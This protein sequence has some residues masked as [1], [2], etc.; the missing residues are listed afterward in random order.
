MRMMTARRRFIKKAMIRAPRNIPGALSAIRSPI[1]RTFW[2][3]WT[4][5][6]S[7]VT[8]EPVL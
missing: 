7:L 3:C 1:I 6:V 2:T 4:S 8:R 5:F